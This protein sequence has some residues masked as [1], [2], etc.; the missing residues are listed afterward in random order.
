MSSSN[1]RAARAAAGF[2]LVAL[3]AIP[4]PV[5]VAQLRADVPLLHAV[6][7]GVAAALVLSAI[8]LIASRRAR[9]AAARSV[10]QAARGLRTARFL[11]WAG[12]YAGCTGAI[13]LA[14]YGVL[15]WA[16]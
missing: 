7:A 6:Y 1:A 11:A 12:L 4:A 9:L 10:S 14:V 5:A 16:Q 2:G 8:A 15:R 13:A 3:V